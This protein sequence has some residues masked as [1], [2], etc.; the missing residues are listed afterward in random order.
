MYKKY[1]KRVLDILIAILLL[2]LLLII[3]I[4]I[5]PIIYF[6]D[7]GNVFY[8]ANR[9]GKNGKIF[10]MYKFRTMKENCEDIRNEDGSTYNGRDDP[11]LTKIGKI[12][13]KASIDEMPQIINVLKGD[14]SFI[15]PRPDLPEHIS[16]YE[17]KE[18]RK[19]EASPGITGYN[20]A[21]FRN[22]IEW[23]D[24]IKND[25]Y[26]ID[27]L[28]FKLDLKIF[29]KT[30]KTIL[31]EE[32]VY[33]ES[34]NNEKEQPMLENKK[35]SIRFLDWD[36]EMFEKKSVKIILN[37][38]ILIEDLNNIKEYI[39]N[40]DY[41]FIT[42]EN[43][44][45]LEKNNIILS[46]LNNIFLADVNIQ[47]A[48]RIRAIEKKDRNDEVKIKNSFNYNEDIVNISKNAFKN[49]RFIF[50][51][52]LND[53][54][55][56]VYSEW[57]KNAF[58]KEDKYFCYYEEKKILGYVLFSIHSNSITIELIAAKSNNKG[59]GTKLM[60]QIEE[61]ALKNNI[62]TLNV[63]TQLNNLNAQNFYEKNGFKHIANNSIYHW[64]IR[65]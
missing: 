62:N 15:G 58:K 50:D 52:N 30:L 45:N 59:I 38:E 44:N 42:F 3:T 53:N 65:R 43:K 12:I 22:S 33:I 51:D 28:S 47:F 9:L 34:K 5:A 13:R 37:E 64:W 8:N 11:R 39:N 21:Y 27:N 6:T 40:N 54:K 17:D 48:K 20:Q 63:G 31:K 14:M 25:I 7:K 49:S 1:I 46:N 16:K 26:Y 2:P 36:T 29:F 35:Y 55:Y 23:K 56:N 18:K 60:N 4:F 41:E 61:F 10:K 32:N 19:L 57:V 24:R